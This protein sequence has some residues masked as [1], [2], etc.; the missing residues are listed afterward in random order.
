MRVSYVDAKGVTFTFPKPVVLRKPSFEIKVLAG[1]D[2]LFLNPNGPLLRITPS[3]F[4]RS[5]EVALKEEGPFTPVPPHRSTPTL[6]ELPLKRIPGLPLRP[7]V[8]EIWV[9]RRGA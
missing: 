9:R 2:G 6:R 7:G 4:L 3:E 1:G 8:Y 5:C